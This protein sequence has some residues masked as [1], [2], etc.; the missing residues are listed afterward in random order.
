MQK[1][2]DFVGMGLGWS[3]SKNRRRRGST[4]DS[5]L[6]A[7]VKNSI[8]NYLVNLKQFYCNMNAAIMIM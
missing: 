4:D 2:G 5:D 7:K 8:K 3:S 6:H 1:S